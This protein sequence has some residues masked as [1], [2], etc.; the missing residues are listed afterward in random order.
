M[1]GGRRGIHLLANTEGGDSS[2]PFHLENSEILLNATNKGRERG[3]TG[4]HRNHGG[5]HRGF[6]LKLCF[7]S[8][9]S[10]MSLQAY[11]GCFGVTGAGEDNGEGS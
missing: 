1:V 2:I 6:I 3:K 11:L 4:T 10:I 9:H 5:G 8:N 7:H